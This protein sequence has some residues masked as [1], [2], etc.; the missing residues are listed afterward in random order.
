MC[1]W[2]ISSLITKI[3]EI[4]INEKQENIIVPKD[5]KEFSRKLPILENSLFCQEKKKVDKIQ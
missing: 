2:S 4:E 3:N 5:G 1:P